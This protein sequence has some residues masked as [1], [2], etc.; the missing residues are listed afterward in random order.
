MFR[1]TPT[2]Q[3]IQ[4]YGEEEANR[5][6]GARR[7][8]L[9]ALRECIRTS[10]LPL[11]ENYPNPKALGQ[12]VLADLTSVINRLFPEGSAPDRL[13]REAAEHEAFARSRERV[14][15]PK[16][17][18]EGGRKRQV[19]FDLLDEHARGGGPPLV[20]LGESGSGSPR[21]WPTGHFGSRT[22]HPED[23]LIMHFIGAT[24]ASA[25]WAAM[26]RRILGEFNRRWNLKIEIP[27]KPD[28]LRSTFANALHMA[29]TKGRVVL[30]LDALNQLEDRDQAPDLVWLP[31]VL[32]E[33]LRVIVSTLPGRP[34][35]DLTK[36]G[37]PT[38]EVKR[39]EPG[40]RIE[41]IREYLKK[42]YSKEL[43]AT[44]AKRVAQHRNRPTRCT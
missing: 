19:Y 7:Q 26:V 40:E 4:Q 42:Y 1:E 11:R 20:V 6:F 35:D 25:D 22:S 2:Q 43:D 18:S 28:A 37:W 23:L 12:L 39:L 16:V 8:K 3:D 21:C 13:D 27:D 24:P 15:I 36:R 14:Y 10:G 5:L 29:A 38:L 33:G 9:K 31:P 17:V 34:L 32:P 30:V 44:S 41:L